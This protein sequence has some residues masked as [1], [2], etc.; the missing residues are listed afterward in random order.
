M[1]VR[2][3]AVLEKT[4]QCVLGKRGLLGGLDPPRKPRSL[5]MKPGPT[6]LAQIN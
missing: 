2:G 4:C 6:S 3:G 1:A 5:I